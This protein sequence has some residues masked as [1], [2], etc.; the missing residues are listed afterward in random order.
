MRQALD[1]FVLALGVMAAEVLVVGASFA[2]IVAVAKVLGA[3]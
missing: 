3:Q 2:V 1:S